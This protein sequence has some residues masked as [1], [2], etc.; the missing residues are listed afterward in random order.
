MRLPGYP[1]SRANAAPARP[2]R[3]LAS[4]GLR[5]RCARRGAEDGCV[6]HGA[7]RQ[8]GFARGRLDRRRGLGA[9]RL[10]ELR[11]VRL[12]QR[13]RHG[14]GFTTRAHAFEGRQAEASSSSTRDRRLALRRRDHRLERQ[15]EGPCRR[16]GAGRLRLA[17]RLFGLR[18][19]RSREGRERVA[20]R[21]RPARRLGLPRRSRA[22]RGR[23]RLHEERPPRVRE[24]APR[25]PERR[26]RRPARRH[27]HHDRLRAGV[28]DGSEAAASSA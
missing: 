26:A 18:S 11:R 20:E 17:R 21:S 6:G 23:R 8:G 16:V 7:R 27:R 12:R 24:R 15:R 14:G 10:L 28:G 9:A 5:G 3:G 1:S 13:R 4:P 2:R 19:E 22:G 25:P